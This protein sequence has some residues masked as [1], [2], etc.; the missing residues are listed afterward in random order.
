MAE[1][2]VAALLMVGAAHAL[3]SQRKIESTLKAYM[4]MVSPTLAA[5]LLIAMKMPEWMTQIAIAIGAIPGIIAA[6]GLI[7]LFIQACIKNNGNESS[8]DDRTFLPIA[9]KMDMIKIL[10]L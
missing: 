5:F 3:T 9:L 10:R 4:L 2:I 8:V 6:G 7:A 1:I